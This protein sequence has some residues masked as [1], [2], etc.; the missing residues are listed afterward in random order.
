MGLAGEIA[1]G[2]GNRCF[3]SMTARNKDI[4]RKTHR[5]EGLWR[6]GIVF[7]VV[8]SSEWRGISS[9]PTPGIQTRLAATLVP[10]W[11]VQATTG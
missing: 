9:S 8:G 3:A 11:V 7:V 1:A 5:R 2:D 10:I 4:A 6:N